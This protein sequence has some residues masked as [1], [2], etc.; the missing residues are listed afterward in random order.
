MRVAVSFLSKQSS[1]RSVCSDGVL[2]WLES[3]A[4]QTYL[5]VEGEGEED[6]RDDDVWTCNAW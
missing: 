4:D 2:R 1:R 3:Q 5:K 6:S